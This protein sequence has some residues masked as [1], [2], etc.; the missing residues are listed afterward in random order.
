MQSTRVQQIHHYGQSIWLDNIQRGAL[1]NGEFEQLIK[2]KEVWGVTSNPSIFEHAIAHTG[3]YD[4]ALNTM[5]RAGW[6]AKDIFWQLAIEDIQV[7]AD[8]LLPVYKTTGHVDGYVSL[9]VDPVLAN[10]T[11]RTVAEALKLWKRV[12]KPN[13]MIKIPATKAGLSSIRK[14]IALGI[15]VNVTLIFSIERYREVINAYLAGL[16]D[17][18]KKGGSIR[19]IHSVASFFVSR[20]DSKVDKV[21]DDLYLREKDSTSAHLYGKAAVASAKLAY[22]VFLHSINEERFTRLKHLGANV[23]RP[24]WASTSTKNPRYRDVMYVEQLIG[25]GTINTL[26]PQTLQAFRQHGKPADT[27]LFG[28]N[29]SRKVLADLE[30]QGI[31]FQQVTEELEME[32][33][34][35]FQKAYKKLLSTIEERRASLLKGIGRMAPMCTKVIHAY[36]KSNPIHWL[37][38][39]KAEYW[40]HDPSGQAEFKRRLGWLDAPVKA[41][42]WLADIKQFVEKQKR[43]GITKVLVLGM[44]GSSLAPEVFS[45]MAGQD[46]RQKLNEGMQLRILDSTDPDQIREAQHFAQPE[47]TLFVV[48]SKSGTTSEVIAFLDYFWDKIHSKMGDRAGSH[49]AA[50]TD[51]GTPLVRLAK[52]KRFSRIFLADK[53]VGGRYS[54]LIHFGLVPAALL[55]LGLETLLQ[56]ASQIKAQCSEAVPPGRNPGVVLG[57]ILGVLARHGVNKLTII[58]DGPIASFGS[59]LE[60]LIAESSGKDGKGILPVDRE[61]LGLVEKYQKDR[62]FVYLRYSGEH[63]A[64]IEKLVAAKIP[65]LVQPITNLYQLGAEMYRWEIAITIACLVIG[66]NPFD[67]PDV[68]LSKTIT[69]EKIKEFKAGKYQPLSKTSSEVG[70][71]RVE[72]NLLPLEKNN[73]SIPNIRKTLLSKIQKGSFIAINAYVDRN[74]DNFKILQELRRRIL[75]DT[76]VA[77]TLGFGPRFQHST[78]QYQ[79]GGPNQGIFLQITQR[80]NNDLAI[81]N[82][83][84]TFGIFELAQAQGDYEALLQRGRKVLR[85]SFENVPLEKVLKLWKKK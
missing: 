1:L 37:R 74:E 31:S 56:N 76:G 64:M 10:D 47:K 20:I 51:P 54:A 75:E 34:S 85:L 59:W 68:Q 39:G 62:V 17:R 38:E 41:D 2:D 24:L 19:Q 15:N 67:Q 60:Q 11:T 49:F 66:V 12:N 53:S 73:P 8:L 6:S 32:G 16:E 61:P 84:L 57:V 29:D 23:Q 50:I 4:D 35:A 30:G 46:H 72:G 28:L 42:I 36:E 48:S 27:I 22:E 25:K 63:D 7:A 82:Q 5:A 43:N 70:G 9:E 83:N 80:K 13:L 81:P 69:E 44:G 40:T 58:S 18:V 26:P 65:V 45:L 78:G 14:A 52:K 79:K 21:L 55:G 33:V 71:I 3:D 77:V